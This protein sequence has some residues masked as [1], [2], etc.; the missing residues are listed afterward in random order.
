MLIIIPCP[1]TKVH[2]CDYSGR[3]YCSDCH[4]K[5]QYAVPARILYNWDFRPR[6]LALQSHE[7]LTF[8]SEREY[9]NVERIN[10]RLFDSV[11]SLAELREFRERI[12]LYK[13][14]F[15]QC[16]RAMKEGLFLRLRPRQHFIDSS[17]LYTLRDL[18]DVN[19]GSLLP[20]IQQVVVDYEK[21][22]TGCSTCSNLK[23]ACA[24]CAAPPLIS[25][26]SDMYS[27]AQCSQ[28]HGVLHR[29]CFNRSSECPYCSAGLVDIAD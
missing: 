29:A 23:F 24:G 2:Q 13:A 9:I 11:S 18:Q 22:Y 1:A 19:N 15:V 5:T 28:C 26:F 21:H 10:P 12:I 16:S 3:Y 27:M 6:P 4:K 17:K 8:L 20:E 14:H 25:P 7:V